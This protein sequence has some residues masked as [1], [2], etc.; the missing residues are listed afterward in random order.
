MHE[1]VF[2]LYVNEIIVCSN[3]LISIEEVNNY[4]KK[5]LK[6]EIKKMGYLRYILRFKVARNKHGLVLSQHNY[7]QDLLINTSMFD[8]KIVD[9]H[10]DHN[11]ILNDDNLRV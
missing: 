2:L 7:I 9:T 5:H 3:D 1:H 10:M 11:F 4:M 8:Y 6:K